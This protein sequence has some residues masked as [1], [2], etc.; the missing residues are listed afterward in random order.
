MYRGKYRPWY[1]FKNLRRDLYRFMDNFFEREPDW[2][3]GIWEPPVDLVET[4]DGYIVVA[5]IPG[6]SRD[7]IKI[8][9]QNGALYLSGEKKSLHPEQSLL[10]SECYY[11]RFRRRLTLPGEIDRDKVSAKYQNGVLQITLPKMEQARA[12]EIKVEVN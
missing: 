9:I 11:G 5:E 1:D 6:M 12:T 3:P 4:E 7:D 8:N 10:K 2:E